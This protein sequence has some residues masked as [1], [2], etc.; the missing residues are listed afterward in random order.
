MAFIK[1]VY[2]ILP[3]GS[4]G[5]LMPYH[6]CFEG[7]EKCIICRDDRDCDTMVKSLFL[8][9]RRKNVLVI[10][11]AVVSNHAHAA[12]LAK[13]YRDVEAFGRELKRTYSQL[14]RK[15][16]SESKVLKDVSVTALLLDT[17]WYLRNALAYILRNAYDNGAE[18]LADY[19]WTGFRA[20]FRKPGL[21]GTFRPVANMTTREWRD[22][23]H[24]GDSLSG[25]SWTVNANNELEPAS[26]CEIDYLE[27]AFHRDEAFFFK[28][29]GIVNTAEMNQK[30]VINPRQMMVD[31]EFFKELDTISQ[32]WY[33][34]GITNLSMS[35]KT[36]L[37]PYVY[38]TL[39]T[40]VSQMARGF[41][42]SREEISRLLNL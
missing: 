33:S 14:F 6:I 32:R 18:Q 28:S 37:I 17:D 8:C 12:V 2:K 13:N 26:A 7:L 30:L 15:R 3:D 36:R 16:Y 31:A 5:S 29:V 24:T 39:K 9:A 1:P 38:H 23:F 41:G 22:I 11:Y 27:M 21:Y 10:I 34:L 19:K 4:L 40:S 25:V 20:C 35:Q 42:V